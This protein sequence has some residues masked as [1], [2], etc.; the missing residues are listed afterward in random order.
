MSFTATILVSAQDTPFELASGQWSSLLA[1][2]PY[3]DFKRSQMRPG[4]RDS[5]VDFTRIDR[6]MALCKWLGHLQVNMGQ[7]DLFLS[8]LALVLWVIQCLEPG[9]RS[10]LERSLAK[11]V[12]PVGFNTLKLHLEVWAKVITAPDHRMHWNKTTKGEV[13]NFE[14][15]AGQGAQKHA[16]LVRRWRIVW[17][18]LSG[19]QGTFLP[20][21]A[22]DQSSADRLVP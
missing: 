11:E 6:I 16:D 15:W 5:R 4:T 8:E 21:C 7:Q 20:L 2:K 9:L 17:G 1:L 3:R 19:E 22:L 14:F 13:D 12:M 10:L 18:R